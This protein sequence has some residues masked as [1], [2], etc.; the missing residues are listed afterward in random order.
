MSSLKYTPDTVNDLGQPDLGLG[1]TV[2]KTLLHELLTR[3]NDQMS[4]WKHLESI[5]C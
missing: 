1:S 5:I 2:K 3:L 4:A